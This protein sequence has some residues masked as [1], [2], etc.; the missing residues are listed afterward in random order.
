[1]EQRT[2]E[3]FGKAVGA[4]R[5]RERSCAEI[6]GWLG[7]RGFEPD[8]CE[9]VVAEL[10]EIGELDDDRFAR[11]FAADKR[12]LSG[13]GAE[14]IEAALLDRGIGRALAERAAAEPRREELARATALARARG[15]DLS[16]ERA[17]S[18][19]LSFLTRRGYGYEL[20]YEAVRD[21]A[22]PGSAAA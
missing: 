20:A 18:R 12:E 16:D 15:E 2:Q 14:R 3:A 6:H 8:I 11:A 19:V 7:D 4:L 10:V 5:R 22:R 21:A 1:V 9:E 13:W 17:R